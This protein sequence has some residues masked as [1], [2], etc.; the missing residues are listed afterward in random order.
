MAKTIWFPFVWA[1]LRAAW[2][3]GT[4][5]RICFFWRWTSIMVKT[6]RGA[7]CFSWC[8]INQVQYSILN[9]DIL[10]YDM[11]W[12]NWYICIDLRL[13][14]RWGWKLLDSTQPVSL[15]YEWSLVLF[16]V[17]FK[18]S[19]WANHTE[20]WSHLMVRCSKL[21]PDVHFLLPGFPDSFSRYLLRFAQ[22]SG[23]PCVVKSWR[24]ISCNLS[25]ARPETW[26]LHAV[27]DLRANGGKVKKCT[28][29]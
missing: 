18:S 29:L 16:T 12:F 13:T 20:F 4:V 15:F 24:G 11:I 21:P 9:H 8:N 5:G 26:D 28:V 1:A 19:F 7:I 14:N 23:F 17:K 3:H 10:W 25:S 6:H 22:Y 2:G 27:K